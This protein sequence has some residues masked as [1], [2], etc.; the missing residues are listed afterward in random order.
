MPPNLSD[1][2]NCAD[3]LCNWMQSS[4]P[5][6]GHV[7]VRTRV[8]VVQHVPADVV[9][10]F[11]NYK[12]IAAIPA[13]VRAS[14]PIPIR[15]LEVESAGQP[16]AVMIPVNPLDVVAVRRA[17]MLKVPMLEGMVDMEALVVGMV[18]PIPMIV[19]DVLRLVDFPVWMTLRFRLPLR[20]LP[21]GRRWGN[22]PLVGSRHIV[23]RLRARRFRVL[24]FGVS[25]CRMLRVDTRGP[26]QYPCAQKQQRV[27]SHLCL[28]G[29]SLSH[30]CR[31]TH[32]SG[33]IVLRSRQEF[34]R[35]FPGF[36]TQVNPLAERSRAPRPEMEWLTCSPENRTPLSNT[37]NSLRCDSKQESQR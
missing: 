11:V 24:S 22:P 8:N 32:D 25:A 30:R 31:P 29:K 35:G 28:L 19:V 36:A 21:M 6:I 14:R 37:C 1:R 20:S 13:P 26:K 9:G 16:E 33:R 10:I 2:V 23:P 3:S 34:H 15:H 5:K 27:A 7:N 17:K 12:V 4:G 18:M